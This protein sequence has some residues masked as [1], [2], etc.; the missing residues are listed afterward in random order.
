VNACTS[1][2]Q[3][4]PDATCDG[5][6]GVAHC[7]ATAPG[8]GGTTDASQMV[9]IVSTVSGIASNTAGNV[10]VPPPTT[11]RAGDVVI[12]LID[13]YFATSPV[14]PT[15]GQ[16]WMSLATANVDADSQEIASVIA[17]ANESANVAR[18]TF[19][20]PNMADWTLIVARGGSGVRSL[21]SS[22]GAPPFSFASNTSALGGVVV[23]LV[24]SDYPS[25][26]TC[27]PTTPAFSSSGHWL[28]VPWP[29]ASG[30]APMVTLTCDASAHQGLL[31][32]IAIEP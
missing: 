30:G 9:T 17:G 32:Q 31:A 3:C 6:S 14:A 2:V 22:T 5:S 16:G 23:D 29:M 8:D 20:S 11:A 1:L 28:V 21:H 19:P 25:I 13:R 15:I 18:Y 27:A 24:A 7:V 10:A 4:P 12:L 26:C